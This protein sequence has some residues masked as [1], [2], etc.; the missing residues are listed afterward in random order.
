MFP[1]LGA[2]FAGAKIGFDNSRVV[3]H[4]GRLAR[5]NWFSGIEHQASP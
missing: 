5:A 4:L 2:Q 3:A 1:G